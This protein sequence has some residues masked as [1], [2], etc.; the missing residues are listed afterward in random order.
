MIFMAGVLGEPVLVGR[1]RELEELQSFLNLAVEGKGTTVFISGEAGTGKTRL[2]KEFLNSA[3][4]KQDISTLAGYCLSN[5][6]VPY[7]PFF[8]AFTSYFTAENTEEQEIKSWLMGPTQAEKLGKREALAPQVWKDQTF[9]AVT[10]TLTAISTKK[11][12]ILLLEDIHWADS[13]SLALM[14]YIAR[15]ISSN[16]I[17]VLATYRSE[18]LTTDA[19]GRPHPLVETLRQM[20]REDL[21]RE[22][23]LPNLNQD[24]VSAIGKSMLGGNLQQELAEKLTE[25]S[26]GNPLYIVETLR[27]LHEQDSLTQEH[28]Q[29]RLSVSELGIP[30]KI[31]D[32]ILQRL[33][34]LMRNQRRVLDAA[35]A[36]GERF[37]VQLLAQVLGQDTLELTETLETIAEATTL[38]CCGEELYSFDH[39]KSR[40]TIYEEISPA[41]K[42]GYHAK[43]AEKLEATSKR[44]KLPLTELAYHYSQAGNGGKAVKY[45]LAAG[46]D[47]LARWSNEEAIKHFA[48]VLESVS[49][50]PEN[51][52]A[53]RKAREGLG[54]AYYANSMFKQA[55]KTFEDLSNSETGADKLRALRKAMESAFQY[56]D[57]PH[58][59][60]LVKKAEPYAAADR[61]E[62]ARV[63]TQ[64]GRVHIFGQ[65]MV[66]L[67]LEDWE[68]ALRAFEEEYSLWDAALALLGAGVQHARLGEPQKGIAGSLRAIALFEELGDFRFQMEACYAAGLTFVHC[69]LFNEALG[70]WAKVIEIDEKTKM[71]D[72]LRLVYANAFS[73]RAYERM[74]YWGEA[75]SH[76]L[77]ALELSK[78]TDSLAAIGMVYSNLS[79]VYVRLGDLKH[80]EE[81][82]KKL[83]ELPP[84]VLL[85]PYVQGVLAKAVF[86]AEKG[87]WKESNQCF[88][89]IFEGF[90]ASPN[91]GME[92]I[93]KLYFAWALERQGRVEEAKVQLE[94]VQKAI[95][96]AEE[97]FAHVSLQASLMVRRE[98]RVGEE[99][100]MRLDLVNVSRKPCLLVKAEAVIPSEGFKVT[101]MLPY[102]S[103]QNGSIEMKNREIGAF[104]VV[105]VKVT[106]Q[107]V[108][109]GTFKLNP[110]AVYL[111]DLG[112]NKTCELDP[113]TVTVKPAQPTLHVIPG[114]ISSGFDE[115]DDLL[116]GGIT[117][118]YAV[119][120][121][122]PSSD[123]RGLLIKR[124]LEAGAEAGETTLYIT[125]EAGNGKALAEKYPSNFYFFLCNPRA[126]AV[127]Q[128]LPNVVK[129]KG[130]ENL[131]EI[132]IALT[133]A[134]R[135]LNPSAGGPRRACIDIVSDVLLQHH[136]VV[137]RKWLSALLAD[138][139]SKGFT[140]LGVIDQNMHPVEEAQAITGL[141]DGEIRIS[142]KETDL[143]MVKSLRIRK[144]TNQRYLENELILTKEK[145]Q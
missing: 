11:P 20:R 114:R 121:A 2:I 78:K 38:V 79:R 82:F 48:Y 34:T 27:M 70:M 71:G 104:Q 136:A 83:M 28:D 119:V 138:F 102:F 145:L 87:Q 97:R 129:L 88:K 1:E 115:L 95:R 139:K 6:A 14:H 60:E 65:D 105:T 47:A 90:K 19:E 40:D 135:T 93:T 126:D 130:V 51:A 17:L 77:K 144:L 25:E 118:N 75:L 67:A 113:I 94:E 96:E 33:S 64:R 31:K 53:K 52:E 59:M 132:D 39:A 21:Y 133:K 15:A 89:E 3:K 123:E 73:S 5:T 36:I 26:Q 58:L 55:A 91:P 122:S 41:L 101:A 16:K 131:T 32:I 112:E 143:G 74:G 62:S 44:E 23:K 127:I 92:R 37:S 49:E 50:N 124:F 7:F 4:Q 86:F 9:I 140:T 106:L 116:A 137:T 61:L 98:V 66:K 46:E 18:A 24:N 13:A 29:W 81:Y 63:L 117:E 57:I 108:K 134:F 142:E 120:L 12:I 10:Q 80:A 76:S 125:A 107:A 30:A 128:S 111:D 141:F 109:A 69:L 45:A 56:M 100:E 84:E 99:F 43:I 103:L 85:N 42:R 22:I 110:K 68:A 72:Y 54:D 35:S 8:E